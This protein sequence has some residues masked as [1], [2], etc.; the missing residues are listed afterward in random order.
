MSSSSKLNRIYLIVKM[1]QP[2]LVQRVERDL[3]NILSGGTVENVSFL[4][5]LRLVQIRVSK[6][7]FY[8]D[9]VCVCV[10]R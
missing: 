3:L 10:C 5:L 6:S 7:N 2:E 4:L 1:L 8:L 9:F